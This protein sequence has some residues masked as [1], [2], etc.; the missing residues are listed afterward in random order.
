VLV[1]GYEADDGADCATVWGDLKNLFAQEGW[2]GT[3]VSVGYY[4]EDVNCDASID[5]AG[6]HSLHYASGHQGD[7]HTTGTNIRHLGYHLAWWI[8]DH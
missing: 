5:D 8:Y 6:S 7:G 4:V 3:V 1:H 2:T